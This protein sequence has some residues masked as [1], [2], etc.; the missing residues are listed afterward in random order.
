[1][2]S[3]KNILFDWDGTLAKTLDIWLESYKSI[4][5]EYEIFPE[6]SEITT[7]VFGDWNG[8]IKLGVKEAQIDDFTEK[9]LEEVN[10]NYASAEL[11]EGAIDIVKQAKSSGKKTAL[12]TSSKLEIVKEPLTRYGFDEL[13]EVILTAESV[14]R[15]KPDPEII[16]KALELLGGGKKDTI[17]IGDS[18][19]D[20]GAGQNAGVDSVLFF[21]E[22]NQLFY[23]LEKLKKYNPTYIVRDLSEIGDI[24]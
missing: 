14:E 12:L 21:P 16:E 20:L 23:E 9:L 7:K 24:S 10:T 11:Y 13:F 6:N 3:Y 15:H 5:A 19:S 8:P 2:K 4:F 1:M 18:K 17:I 22:H